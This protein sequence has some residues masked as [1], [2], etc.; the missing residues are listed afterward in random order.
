MKN[1]QRDPLIYGV[2]GILIGGLMVWFLITGTVNNNFTGMMQM[3]GFRNQYGLSKNIATNTATTNIDRHF[4]EQMIPHHEDAIYMA[5]IALAKANHQEIKNL[6][7]D[8]LRT[9]KAEIDQMKTW[10]RDWFGTAVPENSTVMGMHGMTFRSGMHMGMMGDETDTNALR[11]AQNFDDFE[12]EF[13]KQMIPHHQMA[14]MMANM[15]LQSTNR[16]EMK[17]LAQNIIDAQ[18]QEINNMR[19]WYKDWGY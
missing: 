1:T 19:Q 12:R 3:M 14:A 5:E 17:E 11:N 8:I 7:N 4:I 2:L 9:Q 18:T 15:L 13:I 6:A 16:Q 10:Y